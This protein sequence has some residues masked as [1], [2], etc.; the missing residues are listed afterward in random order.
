MIQGMVLGNNVVR[1]VVAI[2][3]NISHLYIVV[4]VKECI[5][6][7]YTNFK[8]IGLDIKIVPGA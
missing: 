6:V 4:K 1:H 7:D 5:P 2:L 8:C 3:E